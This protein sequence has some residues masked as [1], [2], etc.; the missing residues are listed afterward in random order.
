M[1]FSLTL[2]LMIEEYPKDLFDLFSVTFRL[3]EK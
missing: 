3:I 2:I 1:I